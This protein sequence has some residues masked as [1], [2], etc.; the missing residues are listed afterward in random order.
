M[1][2]VI[3]LENNRRDLGN[4]ERYTNTTGIEWLYS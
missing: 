2:E 3:S 4:D 1:S